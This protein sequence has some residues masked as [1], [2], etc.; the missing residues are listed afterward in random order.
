LTPATAA[1]APPRVPFAAARRMGEDRQMS[2]VAV[3][4]AL[5]LIEFFVFGLLV[6]RAR[7]TYGVPAPAIAGHPVFDRYMRVHQNTMEQLVVF[8]PAMF[9]FATYV[10]APIGA[11]L[12]LL[13]V[14]GRVVYLQGYVKD[15]GKRSAGFAISA[16][17]QLILMLGSVIGALVAW[18][19]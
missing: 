1:L 16:I 14:V 19:R 5:A 18:L 6:G 10:S 9:L 8:V 11:A 3:V 17:P 13:F 4:V 7:Q 15:P 2:M 12:G